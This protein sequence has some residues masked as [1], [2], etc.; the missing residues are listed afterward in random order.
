M[1]WALGPGT[2][3]N[4][5]F[6]VHQPDPAVSADLWEYYLPYLYSCIS[7]FG[8][9]LL[10]CK[11][12]PHEAPSKWGLE[13]PWLMAEASRILLRLWEGVGWWDTSC[14]ASPPT[15]CAPPLASPPCS[16]SLGSCW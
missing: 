13:G 6:L 15:Q 2:E 16:P 8:V 14:S 1:S 11:L 7:L 12:C 9:L 5:G 4:K 3:W 10:L